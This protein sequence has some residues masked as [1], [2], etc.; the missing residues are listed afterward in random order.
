MNKQCYN[1][2]YIQLSEDFGFEIDPTTYKNMRIISKIKKELGLNDSSRTVEVFG[3]PEAFT[4]FFNNLI[5]QV[6][7]H[8]D[9]GY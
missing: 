6:R 5:E 2:Q 4:T 1:V 7:F 9:E 8:L 3:T